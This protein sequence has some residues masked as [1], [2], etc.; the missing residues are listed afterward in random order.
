K[1]AKRRWIPPELKTQ[2]FWE[3]C[4][5]CAFCHK[6]MC[7][8]PADFDCDHVIPA[9]YGGLTCRSNLQL[10]CVRCHRKK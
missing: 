5:R 9:Q 1:P 4:C 7:I 2:I 3:Q 10:L 8:D 6:S